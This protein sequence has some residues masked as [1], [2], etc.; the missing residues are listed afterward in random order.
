MIDVQKIINPLSDKL[1]K[2]LFQHQS[3]NLEARIPLATITQIFFVQ[4][5]FMVRYEEQPDT[6][7]LTDTVPPLSLL[8]PTLCKFFLRVENSFFAT[9]T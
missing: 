3:N 1:E 8:S 9:S 2:P 4:A 7:I 5:T 6:R